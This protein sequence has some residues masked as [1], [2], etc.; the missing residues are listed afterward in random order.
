MV[1]YKCDKCNKLW[2]HKSDF[3]KHIN[4]KTPC[5]KEL[6]KINKYDL[7]IKKIEELENTVKSIGNTKNNTI[8]KIEE[9]ENTVKSIGNT[10]NNTIT[11]INN[12]NNT[13]NTLTFIFAPHAFGKEDL[14][15][16]DNIS[17]KKILNKGF[18]SIQEFVKIIHF[19][20]NKPE[21]HNVYMPN[22]RDKSK[23]LVFDGNRKL[24]NS[25]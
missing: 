3:T 5:V 13:N 11:N 12:I 23:I 25:L 2:K 20:K 19:N 18:K 7:L 8:T 24:Y 21:Y 15:F 9:L 17:S 16:I 4:R 10:K 6:Y 1:E 14:S 22:W